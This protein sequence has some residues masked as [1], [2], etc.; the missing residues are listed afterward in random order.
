M[1]NLV[2]KEVMQSDKELVA[3]Q[4]ELELDLVACHSRVHAA[5]FHCT[6]LQDPEPW[7][8]A[9]RDSGK[10]LHSMHTQ[11]ATS[12]KDSNVHEQIWF[13]EGQFGARYSC[14]VYLNCSVL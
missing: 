13:C 6:S 7:C 4:A 11:H 14:S 1:R 9:F 8:S 5:C 3:V 10:Y 12:S 2:S